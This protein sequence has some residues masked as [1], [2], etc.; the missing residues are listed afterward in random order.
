MSAKVK[1]FIA[2]LQKRRADYNEDTIKQLGR[3]FS[4]KDRKPP[5]LFEDS[6]FLYMRSFDADQGTRPFSNTTF[7]YSPDIN[8][9]PLS[10]PTNITTELQAGETYNIQ[11]ALRNR[12]DLAVPSAKVELFLVDP[13]IGFDVRMAE[14][15]TNL[16]N[17]QTAWVSSGASAVTQFHYTVPSNQA[18]HK[19]L[20]AR[21]FSFSPLDVPF[22]DF[23]LD[24]RL[25]RHVAQQNLNIVAQSSSFELMVFHNPNAQMRL[26]FVP[27]K[28]EDIFNLRHP[29][30][31]EARPFDDIPQREWT[32]ATG[33]QII[34]TAANVDIDLDG[35]DI[36]LISKDADSSGLDLQ[37]RLK[38]EMRK[39][40]GA[41]ASGKTKLARHKNIVAEFRKMN[42]ET[43]ATRMQ[44]KIPDLGLRKGQVAGVQ[45][46]GIDVA[47][48]PNDPIGGFTMLVVGT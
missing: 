28:A 46:Q 45:L 6:S 11:V 47:F 41:V 2:D 20:F 34:K 31:G 14:R 18:G 44:I 43:V 35:N 8:L 42:A 37:R 22:D 36:H 13:S 16:T 29:I 38:G 23:L 12:G 25:D 3:A 26:G 40:L 32:R 5:E 30:L 7:W 19:C 21:C 24:P 1:E 4:R 17:M 10:N 15:L 48:D 33:P 9:S 27:M 39:I